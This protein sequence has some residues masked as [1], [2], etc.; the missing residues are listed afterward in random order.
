MIYTLRPI[1]NLH[2]AV[3]NCFW[4]L[5]GNHINRVWLVASRLTLSVLIFI[6]NLFYKVNATI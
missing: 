3:A 4:Q 5:S 1:F 2:A 6:S